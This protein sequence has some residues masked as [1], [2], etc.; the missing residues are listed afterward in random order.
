MEW[1]ELKKETPPPSTV[2]LGYNKKWVDEDF[3]PEGI[4]ETFMQ[5]DGVFLSAKWNNS[6][7]E[8]VTDDKTKPTH[9]MQRPQPPTAHLTSRA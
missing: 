5:D 7:D 9:W 1:I 8:W 2:V 3:E 4:R 6:M